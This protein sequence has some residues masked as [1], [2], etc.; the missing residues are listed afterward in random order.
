MSLANSSRVGPLF[1]ADGPHRD[2][3]PERPRPAATGAARARAD[4]G[5]GRPC[6]VMKPAAEP[7]RSRERSGKEPRS[8]RA[9]LTFSQMDPEKFPEVLTLYQE[10]TLPT[11]R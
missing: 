11:I 9:R 8:M 4:S 3:P 5:A 6:V 2:A 1:A 10:S 7:F